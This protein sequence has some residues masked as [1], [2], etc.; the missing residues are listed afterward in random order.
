MSRLSTSTVSAPLL[1]PAL[2][3]SAAEGFRSDTSYQFYDEADGRIR[4]ESWYFRGEIDFT[5]D[6]SL[7]FQL[8]RDAIS[9]ASPTGA[10]PGSLQPFLAELEDVRNGVLVALAHQIGDH[11]LELELTQSEESD[12]LSRGLALN[13]KWELNKQNTTVSL[14]FNYVSDLVQVIGLED[15]D[16]T[17]YDGFIG[18]SQVLDKNTILTANLTVS[19]AE[20]YL[21]DPYKNI[22]RTDIFNFVVDGVFT[23]VPVDILYRENRPDSRLRGVFQLQGTRYLPRF[24]AALD[25][26]YRVSHDDFGV[27]SQSLQIE[28]RQKL[29]GRL[30]LTPFFRYYQQSAADFFYNTLDEVEGVTTP[31]AYPAGRGPHYSA[32]Y[33]L[34]ALR[35]LSLGLKARC[36]LSENV[37][38][39]L[40]YERYAMSGRGGASE[41]APA[42]AYPTANIWTFGL[43]IQF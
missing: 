20:G 37:A 41:R 16:K 23:D 32:D 42:A 39:A 43:T 30:Q 11:R 5:A 13:D 3:L 17:S 7:R 1:L 33:R 14:G 28:W 24:Q 26:V 9:G 35:S 36:Q 8:L 15:Q 40:T 31:E 21:N 38:L 19:Y 27:F 22:Q 25:A 6:T 34:S 2:S 29:W 4:V 12:Y 10:Q 18:L